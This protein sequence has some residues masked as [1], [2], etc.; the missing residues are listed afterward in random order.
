MLL[1]YP[2]TCDSNGI[3]ELEAVPGEL[4]LL[5]GNTSCAFGSLLISKRPFGIKSICAIAKD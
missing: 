4:G 3:L 5:H 1:L 2:N